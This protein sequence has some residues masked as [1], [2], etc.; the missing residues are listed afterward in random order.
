MKIRKCP[1]CGSNMNGLDPLLITC[2][3]TICDQN[4][5]DKESDLIFEQDSKDRKEN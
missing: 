2:G 3:S 1:N 5:S 4:L